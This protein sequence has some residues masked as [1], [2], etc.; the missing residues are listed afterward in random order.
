[1]NSDKNRFEGLKAYLTGI[2]RT[3]PD[4]LAFV[5]GYDDWPNLALQEIER[6]A[7]AFLAGLP[8]DELVAIAKR[9]VDL[10]QFA[11]RVQAEIGKE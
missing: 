3:S 8:E 5:A 11:Q 10:C 1:M 4:A 2:G 6:R 7:A 9:E